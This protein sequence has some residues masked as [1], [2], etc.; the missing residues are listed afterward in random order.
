LSQYQID[1]RQGAQIMEETVLKKC[2]GLSFFGQVLI[3]ATVFPP[4]TGVA[5]AQSAE[6]FFEKAGKLTMIVASGAGGGYDQ[7]GRFVARNLSRFLPGNP[8]F[9]IEDMPTAGG[10]QATNFLYN[11]APRDGSVILADTNSSLAL[12]IYDSPVTHYDPRKFEWIGSTGKQQAIC[13]TWKSTGVKTL[14]DAKK[15]EVTVSATAVN[16]GPGVYPTILNSMFGTKFKVIAGYSTSG[17]H[18][19]VER[20][21]VDGLCGLAYQTYLA[22]GLA[23]WFTDEDVNV[24]VQ[25]GLAKNPALPDVPLAD[26]LLKPDDKAVLDLIQAPQ[27]FGRPFVAPPGT[28]ADRMAIYRKAFQQMLGDSQFLAEAK[29]QRIMIEPMDNK[30]IMMLLDNAYSAPKKIH[31]RAAV[32]AA[33][34]D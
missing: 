26:D 24:L 17:M 6:D 31:D 11:S 20:G 32:F 30:Q 7:I 12:P 34:M 27:E 15:R 5:Q 33:Q 18:L 23:N 22:N 29:T 14:D 21:E 10:V 1:R 2:L 16:Q 4:L 19:A 13:L 28:P 3:A 8:P 25:M 9:V